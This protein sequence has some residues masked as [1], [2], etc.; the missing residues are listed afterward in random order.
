MFENLFSERGLSLDRLRVLVEVHDAGGI[1]RAAPDDPVRQSQYSRQLRELSEFFGCEV[2]RRQGKLLKLTPQGVRLTTLVRAHLQA[3]QDFRAECRAESMDY[4]LAAGDSLIQWLVIPRMGE[5]RERFPQVR[6]AMANL[7]TKDIVQQLTDGRIDF[8]VLRRNAVPRTLKTKPLGMLDY[9]L[10]IPR[11]LVRSKREV[12]LG[13][14]LSRLPIASQKSDGQFIRRMH[15]IALAQGGHFE[16]ALLCESFPQSMCAVKSLQFAAF[17]PR[18]ATKELSASRFHW[19][20]DP[21]LKTQSREL[22]LA[23]NPR[24][25]QIRTVSTRLADQ[26]QTALRLEK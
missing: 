19:V 9:V 20:Q 24:G 21:V 8:G 6:I 11:R 17:V 12:T 3:L 1:A 25:A 5:V 2:A 18:I 22:V 23:W 14:A 10:A 4:T 16:P 26:L 7:R 13:T 15:D